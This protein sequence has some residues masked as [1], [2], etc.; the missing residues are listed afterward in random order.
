MPTI[1]PPAKS[2]QHSSDPRPAQKNAPP[3]HGY[4][5]VNHTHATGRAQEKVSTDEAEGGNSRR[6]R[7]QAGAEPTV[8][9]DP[10][11]RNAEK[12]Y[13]PYPYQAR[14][15]LQYLKNYETADGRRPLND[16]S[17][18]N[19][20]DFNAEDSMGRVHPLLGSVERGEQNV[21]LRSLQVI[22]SGLG[23]TMAKLLAGLE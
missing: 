15:A 13:A 19:V 10:V 2:T 23:T 11:K 7:R 22:A 17:E 9:A 12:E 21:T 5:L 20:A 14:D 3:E 1:T 18:D 8:A 6:M 4:K 16:L